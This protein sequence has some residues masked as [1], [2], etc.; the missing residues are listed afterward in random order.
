MAL[1]KVPAAMMSGLLVSET[2]PSNPGVGQRWYKASTAVTYQY[3]NDGT[4][5]FWL[6]VTSGGIGTSAERGV[7]FVG[8]TDPHKAT[9]GTALAVGS[10]YY[11]REKNRYFVCTDATTNANVW[12]GRYEGAGGVITD[13]V[14]SGTVYRS[15]TFLGTDTFYVN[16]DTQACD[17]LAI[18][19][20]AAG[21]S[22]RR[23]CRRR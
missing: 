16:E 10:I 18:G 12:S 9:N 23:T 15:H 2:A 21:G 4:S 13:Y 3:T 1:D 14:I 6:D 8:D 7:D 17:V 22:P 11:N 19:G 5:S 20:G